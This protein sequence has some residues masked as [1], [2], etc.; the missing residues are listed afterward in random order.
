LFL[1]SISILISNLIFI[2]SSIL[3]VFELNF[4]I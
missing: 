1:I 2:S 3:I 4:N